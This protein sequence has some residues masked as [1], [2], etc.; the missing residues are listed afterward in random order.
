MFC[1]RYIYF[2]VFQMFF[3]EAP[4][5]F[6]GCPAA[7]VQQRNERRVGRWQ[8]KWG[9]PCCPHPHSATGASLVELYG[10]VI[11]VNRDF[12]ELGEGRL[13]KQQRSIDVVNYTRLDI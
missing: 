11:V 1:V 13:A 9:K 12:A 6:P 5:V 3:P 7:K 10:V 2:F 4:D 8:K